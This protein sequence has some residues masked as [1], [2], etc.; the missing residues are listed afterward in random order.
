MGV[1]ALRHQNHRR[2]IN[3][4]APKLRQQRR[5]DANVANVLCIRLGVDRR[6]R[7]IEQDRDG[8]RR[9]T[10]VNRARLR[11]QI[12]RREVLVLAFAAIRRELHGLAV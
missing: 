9:G 3:R 5:L 2:E 7:V 12:A 10:Y 4:P 1:V 8:W 6:D 11:Q